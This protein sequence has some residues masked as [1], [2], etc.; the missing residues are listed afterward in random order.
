LVISY[1]FSGNLP[2]QPALS[3]GT[4]TYHVV[5]QKPLQGF[6]VSPER[7]SPWL[8]GTLA[9]RLGA[10]GNGLTVLKLSA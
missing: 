7:R 6:N 9:K 3:I 5:V 8:A 4:L 10:G 1:P 2:S